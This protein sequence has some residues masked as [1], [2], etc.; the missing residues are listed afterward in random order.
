MCV[1]AKLCAMKL[2][3]VLL[4]QGK[5]LMHRYGDLDADISNKDIYIY[6]IINL[7]NYVAHK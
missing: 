3:Q 7:K 6:T 4:K 2:F 1:C 5:Y